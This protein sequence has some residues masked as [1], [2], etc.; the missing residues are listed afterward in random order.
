M[1]CYNGIN[2]YVLD[3]TP[4]WISDYNQPDIIPFLR[5][6]GA[7]WALDSICFK[8]ESHRTMFLLKFYD[9]L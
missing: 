8:L 5:K 1:K 6:L 9:K 3:L 7:S 2:Y 4:N